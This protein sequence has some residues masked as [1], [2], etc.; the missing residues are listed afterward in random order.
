MMYAETLMFLDVMSCLKKMPFVFILD[1]SNI[2]NIHFILNMVFRETF[3]K[4]LYTGIS[5][6]LL[7]IIHRLFSIAYSL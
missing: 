4:H 7:R 5:H 6:C 3:K 2:N 1:I